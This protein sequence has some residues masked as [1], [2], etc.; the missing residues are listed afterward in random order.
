[1]FSESE[2]DLLHSEFFPSGFVQ[3]SM[4]HC[5]PACFWNLLKTAGL[6][7]LSSVLTRTFTEA[8]VAVSGTACTVVPDLASRA[9]VLKHFAEQSVGMEVPNLQT[10]WLL[11][12][13]SGNEL[14]ATGRGTGSRLGTGLVTKSWAC[15]KS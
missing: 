15:S 1:M 5:N 4:V 13:G 7:L 6:S 14:T 8:S 2:H 3:M 11:V 9:S 10:V 12:L